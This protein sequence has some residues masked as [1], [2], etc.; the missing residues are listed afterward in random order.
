M[1]GDGHEPLAPDERHEVFQLS[2]DNSEKLAGSG[3]SNLDLTPSFCRVV[4]DFR[5]YFFEFLLGDLKL[6][7]RDLQEPFGRHIQPLSEPEFF[8][9]ALRAEAE[10]RAAPWRHLFTE[11]TNVD[12]DRVDG[13]ARCVSQIA[14]YVHV[15]KIVKGPR[16]IVLD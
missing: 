8:S 3:V 15:L 1:L 5:G 4:M 6:S 14:E 7:E 16:Q 10:R 9:K 11:V 12:T 13:G 2:L